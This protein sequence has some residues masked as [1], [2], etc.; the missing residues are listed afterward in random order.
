VI[1]LE[2]DILTQ[3]EIWLKEKISKPLEN[4]NEHTYNFSS[5]RRKTFADVLYYLNYLRNENK[6]ENSERNGNK[7]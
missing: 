3:L 1:L 4:Y 2:K 6:N 5:S 7:E